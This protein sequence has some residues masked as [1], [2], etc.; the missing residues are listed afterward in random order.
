MTFPKLF[1]P[2]GHH[3]NHWSNKYLFFFDKGVALFS[4]GIYTTF[5]AVPEDLMIFSAFSTVHL[6]DMSD[7]TGVSRGL[8]LEWCHGASIQ[9][10]KHSC[11]PEFFI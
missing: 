4:K 9:Y 2:Q 8:A 3:D 1:L 10:Q 11:A 6:E 7:D 5:M